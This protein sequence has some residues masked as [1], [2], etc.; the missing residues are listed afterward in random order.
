MARRL[1]CPSATRQALDGIEAG[2]TDVVADADTAA[3]KLQLSA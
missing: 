2:A 3:A 1:V